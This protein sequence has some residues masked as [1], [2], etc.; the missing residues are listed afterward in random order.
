MEEMFYYQ[1][2]SYIAKLICSVLINRP[3][4]NPWADHFG[5]EKTQELIVRKYYWQTLQREVEA[6]LDRY[7]IYVALKAV[8]HKPYRDL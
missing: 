2:L 3:H 7:N 5:I 1:D 8:C 6:Y 4:D